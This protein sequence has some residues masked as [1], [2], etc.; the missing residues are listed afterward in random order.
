[1]SKILIKNGKAL[2][3]KN[4]DVVIEEINILIENSKIKKM[5]KNLEDSDYIIS[6]GG[7]FLCDEKQNY[8][9][10]TNKC[11]FTCTNEHI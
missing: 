10:R 1:M 9:A 2:I 3:I 8:N 4:N 11:T 7:S 5:E 6:K